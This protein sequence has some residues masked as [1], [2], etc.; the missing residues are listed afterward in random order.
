MMGGGL[1]GVTVGTPVALAVV[2]AGAVAL[3]ACA[4]LAR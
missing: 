1:P 3:K 2:G 4:R